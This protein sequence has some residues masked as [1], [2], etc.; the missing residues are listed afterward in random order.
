M[1]DKNLQIRISTLAIRHDEENQKNQR[2]CKRKISQPQTIETKNTARSCSYQQ[3]TISQTSYAFLFVY[4]NRGISI[5]LVIKITL[6]SSVFIVDCDLNL[7][8]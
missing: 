1:L 2:K 5:S 3:Q 4:V 6:Y 7:P 8:I